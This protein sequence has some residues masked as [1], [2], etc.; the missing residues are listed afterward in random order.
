MTDQ[1][2]VIL[3]AGIAGLGAARAFAES[4]AHSVI[5]ERSSE[6]GGHTRSHRTEHGFVFDEGPHVSFTQNERVQEIFSNAVDGDYT[7]L[8]SYV[9]NYYYGAWIKHPAQVNLAS[10]PST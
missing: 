6:S 4:G 1:K 3:G 7:K 10:L 5:Y 9:D 2:H 8:S